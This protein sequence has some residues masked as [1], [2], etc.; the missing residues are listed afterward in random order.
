MLQCFVKKYKAGKHARAGT[1]PQFAF[2]K[3]HFC[4]GNLNAYSGGRQRFFFLPSLLQK[5]KIYKTISERF[6]KGNDKP[7]QITTKSHCE[8][9]F[10]AKLQRSATEDRRGRCMMA[11]ASTTKES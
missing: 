3:Y 10:F 8:V 9:F 1:K 2:Q 11:D 4:L 6:F 7:H 5:K